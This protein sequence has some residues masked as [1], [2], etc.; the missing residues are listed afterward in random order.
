MSRKGDVEERKVVKIFEDLGYGAIRVPAS[1]ARTKSDKPDVIAGNGRFHFAVEVKSSK[2]DYIYIR[3]KQVEEL[4]RFSAR[5]GAKP[6]I[7]A[8]FTRLPYTVFNPARLERTKNGKYK[9]HRKDVEKNLSLET[10]LI[11]KEI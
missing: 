3:K 2:N 8:H 6:L 5:F 4:E 10:Y 9:I 7:V 1:G 11:Q